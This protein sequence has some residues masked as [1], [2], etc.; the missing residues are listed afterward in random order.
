MSTV[1][2]LYI[3]EMIPN[4]GKRIIKKVERQNHLPLICH[5]IDIPLKCTLTGQTFLSMMQGIDMESAMLLK[6]VT[7]KDYK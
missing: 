5:C 7:G 4:K 3:L 1:A 6:M 2:A